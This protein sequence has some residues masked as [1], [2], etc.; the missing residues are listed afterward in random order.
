MSRDLNV[1]GEP[2]TPCC[3]SPKTG[4]YRDGF[5]RVGPEDVGIHA[6]CA[7]M[8]EEF[9]AYSLA[10]GNDLSTPKPHCCPIVFDHKGILI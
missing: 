9:L 10:Q 4:F 2:L 3:H 8:T 5:C 7:I 6:I 1:L